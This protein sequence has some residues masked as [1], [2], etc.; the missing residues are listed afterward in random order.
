MEEERQDRL[1]AGLPER[2]PNISSFPKRKRMKSFKIMKELLEIK[3]T[4]KPKRDTHDM[5][6]ET[7]SCKQ[8]RALK[9]DFHCQI[10]IISSVIERAERVQANLKTQ[11]PSFVKPMIRSN[12]TGGFWLSLP[13]LFCKL[14]LPSSDIKITLVDE[15]NKEYYTKYLP[16]RRGLSAGWRGFS[17]SHNLEEGDVLVFHLVGVCKMKV[18]IVRANHFGAV[19]AAVSLMHLRAHANVVNHGQLVFYFLHVLN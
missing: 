8:K 13:K 2:N 11:F 1:I 6:N 10:E 17:L 5:A 7:R 12:V 4:H 19:D 18:Y 14:H 9:N 15:S 16:E 3:E